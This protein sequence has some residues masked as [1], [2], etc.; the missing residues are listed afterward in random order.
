MAFAEMM[1]ETQ[2]DKITV[3][4]LC[5][6]AGVRRATFYK[7]YK[8]KYDFFSHIVSLLQE[9]IAN[10]L[11]DVK[12]KDSPL[13][14]YIRYVE[15]IISYFI[16]NDVIISN[17]LSSEI[18]PIML[19]LIMMGTYNSLKNDLMGDVSNG[20]VLAADPETTAGFMNGG[21]SHILV[22]WAR[23][24]YCTK[25]ELLTEVREIISKLISK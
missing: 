12:R 6:R 24:R 7:H 16:K 4:D 22:R 10:N 23:L 14:Y 21:I 2:F 13:D 8:D 18:F 20:L 25:E 15:E 11:T 3:Y 19:N 17:M 9:N 5:Q 1:K